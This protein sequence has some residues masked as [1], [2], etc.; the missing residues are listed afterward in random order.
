MK[1]KYYIN[2]VIIKS[3]FLHYLKNIKFFILKKKINNIF[4]KYYIIYFNNKIFL[5][6][7]EKNFFLFTSIKIKIKKKKK[8]IICLE[9]NNIN[10]LIK[11]L[12]YNKKFF[13]IFFKKK[14][15]IYFK[16]KFKYIIKGS[17][18]KK[19]IIKIIKKKKNIFIYSKKIIKIF[20]F[21][22][23]KLKYKQL[24]LNNI[25]IYF[26]FIKNFLLI[27]STDNRSY[28]YRLKY[29][30]NFFFKKK[31]I[32]KIS[33]KAIYFFLKILKKI[34]FNLKI[35]IFTY[36]KYICFILL[37]SI[38]YLKYFK[39][40]NIKYQK[41]I[42]KKKKNYLLISRIYI[43]KKMIKIYNIIKNNDYL[44]IINLIIKRTKIIIKIKNNNF[45]LKEYLLYNF[46]KGNIIKINI[47]IY[48]L[49]KTLIN[50]DNSIIKI[51]I[52]KKYIY[53][54][55]K[56]KKIIIMNLIDKI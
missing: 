29:K 17:Q 32:Y 20:D 51:Y 24:F 8:K 55:N 33:K 35:K 37:K 53:I 52:N 46:Y 56:N 36:K 40:K 34:K 4:N 26:I 39:K 54:K 25:N 47:N 18:K 19:K 3:F 2:Y 38:F 6:L 45:L 23:L 1:K 31:K 43:L 22:F 41:L 13:F 42:K 12:I 14:I 30:I 27:F 15:I 11:I 7:K 9:L 21:L 49:I 5:F 50:L 28:L 44:P 16:K 10:I 48:I